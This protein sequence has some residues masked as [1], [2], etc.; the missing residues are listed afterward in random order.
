MSERYSSLKHKLQDLGYNNHLPQDAVPIVECI[1]ADLLQTTRSLQHYMDLSKE[2]LKQRDTLMLE[3]EPYKRDNAKLIQENNQLHQEV[4]QIKE[5]NTKISKESKRKLKSLSEEVIKKDA[6]ISKLQH[7][8]RDLSLRGLCAGTFS[9][10]NKCRRKNAEDDT[11]GTCVLECKDKYDRDVLEL[12]DKLKSLEDINSELSDEINLLKSKVEHRDNE[13]VRLNMLLQGGRP[14]TLDSC[15]SSEGG[16]VDAIKENQELEAIN[17]VLKKEIDIGLEKQHEAML[18]ALNL[19]D[20]N[21]ALQEELKKVDLLALKVEEDCNKR[22]STLIDEVNCLQNKVEE[23]NRKNVQLENELTRKAF[24]SPRNEIVEEKLN[25]CLKQND[26]LQDEMK[27]L[28]E[29]NKKLQEK[30]LLISK[31]NQEFNSSRTQETEKIKYATKS[32]LQDLLESERKMHEKYMSNIEER[33][34]ETV[35]VLN[36]HLAKCKG[37]EK[38]TST[39]SNHFIRDLQMKLCESEQK[40][41]MLKKERDDLLKKFSSGDHMHS[42]NF[43]DVI[44]QLNDENAELSKEN[45]FLSQQLNHYKTIGTYKEPR[46]DYGMQKDMEN[47]KLESEKLISD[48]YMLRKDKQEYNIRYKEAMDLVERYKRDLAS[49]QEEINILQEENNSYKTSHRTGKASA[50]HLREECNFLREQIKR[51]QSDVIKEKT[52]A[53]QIKNIQ[54]E[55]ERS[56]HEIQNDL[57]SLQ[58]K[59]SIAKDTIESL[60]RKCKDLQSEVLSLNSEKSNLIENIKRVDQERDKVVIELDN[61]TESHC[62]LEQ[63]LKSQTYEISKLEQQLSDMKRMLNMNKVAEHKVVDYESQIK[64]LN[65]EIA[66]LTHQLDNAVIE[67]KHLQNSLEDANGALKINKIEHDKSRKEAAELRQ[68]LQHYVVEIKR[69]EELLSHKEAERS[70]MLEHFASL[71]V[72]ANIL[73]NTNHS[74]ESESASKSMQ[75]QSYVIK[76]QELESK[77]L[78]KES[79]LDSQSAHITELTCKISRLEKEVSLLTEEKYVLEQNVDHLKQMC[80]NMQTD[81]KVVADTDSELKLYETKI[82]SLT[83]RKSK[84]ERENEELSEKLKVTE[85]LL[86]NTRKEVI[87][88]KLAL[89]DATAETQSLHERVNNMSRREMQIHEVHEQSLT[90]DEYHVPFRMEEE[91]LE[92]INE[93][94]DN[95]KDSVQS[96]ESFRRR[97]CKYTHGST[98]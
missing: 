6:T 64:F 74:L 11:Y 59:H 4:M 27:N 38:A 44:K 31:E 41:L 42:Q 10:R 53:N 93:E 90:K 80:S 72:E 34:S 52:M 35:T 66:R 2:T 47:H 79:K 15:K 33:I 12:N 82:K 37:S 7:E 70:D 62:V 43:K 16:H 45:I 8:V 69:I 96:E 26:C 5:L 94:D 83:T 18:R 50:D 63:K 91:I 57:M 73:E 98:L 23:L 61:K 76:I 65:G 46:P 48:I 1:L 87:E 84:L 86:S 97:F 32:E 30:V 58:K 28:Q 22:L 88:L 24:R 19:A 51:M 13:I 9:S 21:K 20:K 67:N 92:K 71:S 85:R 29:L 3:V 81:K 60:E 25:A 40:I 49:K 77:I 17:K 56:S 95:D 55:T 68:Q 89:Q 14:L 75:L 54:L 36:S 39:P 78:D